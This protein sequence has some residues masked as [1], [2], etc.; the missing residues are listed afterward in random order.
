MKG[1]MPLN[2]KELKCFRSFKNFDE[3]KFTED[4]NKI[5]FDKLSD[6]DDVNKIY[7]DFEE[8]FIQTVDKHAPVKQRKPCQNPAPF[9]NKELRKLCTKKDSCII[10]IINIKLRVTGKI[11]DNREI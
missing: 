2:K 4:L 7:S 5:D 9:I 11:I 1:N 6:Q 10:N 8:A 3:K